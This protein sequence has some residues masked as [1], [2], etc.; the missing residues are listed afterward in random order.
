NCTAKCPFD[1]SYEVLNERLFNQT[2]VPVAKQYTLTPLTKNTA[3]GFPTKAVFVHDEMLSA[4]HALL[5]QPFPKFFVF[6]P[7]VHGDWSLNRL[8]FVA[9]CLNEMEEVQV[10]VGDTYEV[11]MSKGVGQ[12]LTQDTPNLKLKE[13]L[14]PFLP[15]WEPV[16]KFVDIEISEK[17][18]K[19]FSRYWDKVG[20]IVMGDTQYRKP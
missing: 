8:Q 10:W 9:D 13:L 19:R 15:R 3:S 5:K 1:A 16:A 6:D 11:L 4:A 14:A 12:V 18:L 7:K 17:R 20:P 2:L